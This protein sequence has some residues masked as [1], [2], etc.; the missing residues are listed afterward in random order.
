MTGYGADD[1]GSATGGKL[2]PTRYQGKDQALNRP[3]SLPLTS[4][5]RPPSKAM[6]LRKPFLALNGTVS[7]RAPQTLDNV[8]IHVHLPNI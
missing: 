2:L 1:G 8:S 7:C 5:A 6:K 4:L 3:V